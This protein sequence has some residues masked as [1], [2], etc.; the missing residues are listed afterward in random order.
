MHLEQDKLDK[1]RAKNALTRIAIAA[2]FGTA[3]VVGIESF[4]DNNT[5]N[6]TTPAA[7]TSNAIDYNTLAPDQTPVRPEEVT[8]LPERV[9]VPSASTTVFEITPSIASRPNR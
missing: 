7:R 8:P 2:A 3:V 9:P 4:Q 6:E 1:K 5:Q